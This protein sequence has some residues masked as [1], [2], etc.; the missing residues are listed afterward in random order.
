MK[1]IKGHIILLLLFATV[2]LQGQTMKYDSSIIKAYPFKV[3][4]IGFAVDSMETVV[5]KVF[6]GMLYKH[7]IEMFNFGKKPIELK[8]GKSSSFVELKYEPVLIQPGQSATAFVDFD[9]IADLPL[10]PM[11]VELV[12]ETND[13]LNAFKFLYLLVDIVEDSA[14]FQTK[15]IIDTVPRMIFN[16][17]NF[18]F[19]HLVRGKKVYHTFYFTNMGAQD[20]FV[21]KVSSSNACKVVVSPEEI[22]P[23]GES[24]RLVVQ[25]KTVGNIG[26]QHRTISIQTNDPVNPVIILGVHGT[27]RQPPPTKQNQGFCYE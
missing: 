19:G 27:V 22:I 6:R 13:K 18:D 26:V 16:N 9:V 1:N 23:P 7:Q 4:N 11:A 10:G 3:G 8:G 14:K 25:V 24:G 20:L 21:E 12:V 17:Y 5:G 15:L 2:L